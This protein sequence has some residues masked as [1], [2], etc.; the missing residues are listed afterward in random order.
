[1]PDAPPTL[2]VLL[3]VYN[4]EKYLRESLDSVLAQTFRDFEF[5][6]IDD[7]STDK[8]LSILQEYEAKDSRIR[9]I[10]RPNKG[11]TNTLNEG[12][13]LA[14][15][16][17]L[18]RMDADDFCQPDRFEKQVAYLR[19]HPDCLLVGSRVQVIDPEGSPIRLMCDET[20]HEQ[21][22]AAHLNRQWPIVHPAVTMR[23]S[24]L[25]QIGGYRNMYNT[26]EDLD[27]F[28]RLAEIGKLANLPDVLLKYRQHFASVTHSR[29]VQ[30]MQIREA[31]YSEA[32]ARRGLP[33]EPAPVATRT[34]A[35]KQFE[36]HRYWAWSALQ[37]G[38]VPT[39]RKHA[40]KALWLKPAALDSWR[41]VACALRGY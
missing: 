39:A 7:G 31:I 37:A 3:A 23:M 11:L 22:D 28:L 9:L 17:F 4:G 6:I 21:I 10:S 30:Q 5:L 29:E 13:S 32:R 8:T 1:M 36:Q 40:W 27:V 20:T 25:R 33:P 34:R 19:E 15:G 38:N 24:G 14:R 2:T 41:L 26:L 16:E 12:L 35:R 18:A